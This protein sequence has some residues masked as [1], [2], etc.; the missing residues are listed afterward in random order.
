MEELEDRW[1]LGLRGIAVA[2]VS[3]GAERPEL[4]VSLADGTEIRVLGSWLLTQGA[5]SAPG[6]TPLPF[7]E[8]ENVVGSAVASA[9]LFKTGNVRVV[10]RTGLHLTVRPQGP[11]NEAHVRKAGTFEWSSRDGVCVMK[12]L[13]SSAP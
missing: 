13:G 2:A 1:I 5:T 10:F 4:V 9:V 12:V 11:G 3:R 7:E 8:L 6:A